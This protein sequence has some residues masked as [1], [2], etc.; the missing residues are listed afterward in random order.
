MPTGFYSLREKSNNYKKSTRYSN[1]AL[2]WLTYLNHEKGKFIK[3]AE[4]SIHGE[5]RIENFIVDGFEENT[6][7]V[8]EFYG[9]YFHGH[10]CNSKYDSKK[11]QKTLKRENDLK[12][13]GYNVV[14]MTSCRWQ[15][16]EA[17]KIW[18]TFKEISCTYTDILTA[19]IENKIFGIVKCDLHVPQN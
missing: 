3:H 7:T 10:N 8:Y 4:N 13:L 14:S 2:Q 6:N 15:Q 16:Q 9:C 1:Q 18:Y 17:S 11:W 5:V 12:M 19:I